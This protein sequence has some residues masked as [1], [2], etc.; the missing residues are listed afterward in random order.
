MRQGFL[1]QKLISMVTDFPNLRVISFYQGLRSIHLLYFFS[2]LQGSTSE[3]ES[4]LMA[5]EE[6]IQGSSHPLIQNHF[7]LKA[8]CCGNLSE[9]YVYWCSQFSVGLQMTDVELGA[10]VTALEENTGG[11]NQNGKCI[12]Y[13]A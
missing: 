8:F 2:G 6:N 7:L 13:R 4:Q 12:S 11:N 9:T 3:L 1:L 10:R 5:A